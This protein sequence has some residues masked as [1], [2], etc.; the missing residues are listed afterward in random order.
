MIIYTHIYIYY[1]EPC[2]I[3]TF[4]NIE[5]ISEMYLF[6][7]Y[8]LFKYLFVTFINQFISFLVRYLIQIGVILYLTIIYHKNMHFGNVWNYTIFF[9]YVIFHQNILYVCLQKKCILRQ[10][11]FLIFVVHLC[12]HYMNITSFLASQVHTTEFEINFFNVS[13]CLKS[14]D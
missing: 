5:L 11:Y 6:I 1:Y 8:D 12:Q 3:P 13:E 9:H 7:F 4:K 14:I 10:W 2:F